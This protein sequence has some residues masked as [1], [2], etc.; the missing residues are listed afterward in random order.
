VGL[1][2][3]LTEQAWAALVAEEPA[4]QAHCPLPV[5]LTGGSGDLASPFAVAE[6]AVACIGVALMAAACLQHQ[7]DGSA[8]NLRLNRSH[9]EAAVRSERFFRQGEESAGVGFAPLSRF[10]RTSDGWV[11][12]HANY[13]WHK[14]ALLSALGAPEEIEAVA[15]A[16]AEMRAEEVEDRVFEAGGIAAAVR[17]FGAWC[18]HPQGQAIAAEPLIG[19]Q[20]AG[21]APSRIP[22]VGELP[23]AGV[24]VL[25][26]TRVIAG[27]VCTRF[28]A[29]L[30]AQVLRLDPPN[31]PDM[32]PG[33]SAD[34]L[35]GKRS[36][37]LDFTS[38]Q[39]VAM[40]H[41][42]L[43]E[44]D[45]VV[46]GYRPGALDRFGFTL[47]ALA[48]R[49]PGIVA[50]FLNAWG[51]SGPWARRRGFDSVVQAPTGIALGE[52]LDGA[53]PGALPCQLLDHGTGYLAAAAAL[54]G[55]RRQRAHGGT[56][57]RSL[58]LA[59]TAWWLTSTS[60]DLPP[61]DARVATSAS[62]QWVS[63]MDGAQG[64]VTAVTPPGTLNG[65]SLRWPAP[66]TGYGNDSPSW[67]LA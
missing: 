8:A 49:H 48:E 31:H 42:L 29:A 5:E 66:T 47:D 56:H 25:D 24:R 51:H 34:S 43:D 50:L 35:L 7:R 27:P 10:W 28:L 59:R 30:G 45:V 26:L 37:M 9:A 19:H 58:S 65:Q 38:P 22:F 3:Q 4:T 54:D 1:E 2:A 14:A 52:S 13:R 16:M 17:S 21:E 12:T 63:Q 60:T 6:T 32:L 46:C 23:A 36:A 67:P 11:R 39:G 40:L 18:T 61:E 15:A 55:L 53:E 62:S 44:A 33:A 64:P 20:V 57:V 41:R